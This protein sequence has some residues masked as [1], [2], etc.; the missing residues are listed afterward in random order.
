MAI[1]GQAMLGIENH[2]KVIGKRFD[3]SHV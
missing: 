2:T 3:L 1:I